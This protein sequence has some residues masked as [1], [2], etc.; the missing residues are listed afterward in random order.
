MALPRGPT[1]PPSLIHKIGPS[2]VF[3]S[4]PY[5]RTSEPA[6]PIP[7]ANTVVQPPLPVQFIKPAGDL[8]KFLRDAVAK[9]QNGVLTVC[10]IA[11]SSRS[12]HCTQLL[13][14]AAFFLHHNV[15]CHYRMQL[16]LA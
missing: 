10:A 3:L 13:P 4:P 2:T 11:R 7:E 9:I 14:Y 1:P 6:E 12:L 5:T 8:L 16:E 15:L